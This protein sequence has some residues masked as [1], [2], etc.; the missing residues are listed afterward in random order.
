MCNNC[1]ICTR[2][3][4]YTYLDTNPNSYPDTYSYPDLDADIYPRAKHTDPDP[5]FN[6]DPDANYYT[7]TL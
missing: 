1:Y 3:D 5:Y 4:P 7:N 2:S 6:A